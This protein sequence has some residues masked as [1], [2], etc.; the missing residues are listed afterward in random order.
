[1]LIKQFKV[2]DSWTPDSSVKKE[3]KSTTTSLAELGVK[4]DSE[5]LTPDQFNQAKEVLSNWSYIFSM[6]LQT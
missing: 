4:I 6:V 1:M 2:V 5:N 3:Q